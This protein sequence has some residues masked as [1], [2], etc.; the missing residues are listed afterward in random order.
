[1]RVIQ[2]RLDFNCF[3]FSRSGMLSVVTEKNKILSFAEK[4]ATYTTFIVHSAFVE[5]GPI[6]VKKS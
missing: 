6:Q 4:I 5:S 2:T 1:M 3:K